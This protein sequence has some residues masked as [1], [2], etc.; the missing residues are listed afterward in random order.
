MVYNYIM[1]VV[2]RLSFIEDKILDYLVSLIDERIPEACSIILFGSRARAG[3]KGSSDENSDT[4][5]AIILDVPEIKKE[6]WE[7]IWDLKWK[8]LESLEAEEFPLSLTLLTL[9]DFTS[10]N[11]G[12]EKVL[13]DEGIVVWERNWQRQK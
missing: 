6:H 5:V 12:F 2:A 9:R 1:T 4:D 11:S 3:Y 13:R 7:R 10:R 8:V